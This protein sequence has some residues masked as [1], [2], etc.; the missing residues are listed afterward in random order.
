MAPFIG[1]LRVYPQGLVVAARGSRAACDGVIYRGCGVNGGAGDGK[2]QVACTAIAFRHTWVI[3]RKL[4]ANDLGAIVF[5]FSVG[6]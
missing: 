5:Y 6:G 2:S 1:K 4:V 3:Y